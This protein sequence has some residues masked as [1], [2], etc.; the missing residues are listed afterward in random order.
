MSSQTRPHYTT[1]EYLAMERSS[2][3]RHEYHAGEVFVMSGASERHKLS[4]VKCTLAL[5]EV[6]D[7]VEFAR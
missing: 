2:E 4:S 1:E 6:Y 7:K 3:E 5:S